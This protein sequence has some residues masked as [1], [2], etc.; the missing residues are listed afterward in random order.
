[1]LALAS[2]PT[3]AF[4]GFNFAAPKAAPKAP[5]AF[6]YGLPGNM[7]PAGDFDPA[8]FLEG[9]SELEV[10]RYREVRARA[11]PEPSTRAARAA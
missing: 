1:M 8:G 4:G 2:A 3:L 9:K 5:P 7:G 6:C 11:Q 10:N